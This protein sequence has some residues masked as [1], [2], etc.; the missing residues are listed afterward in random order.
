MDSLEFLSF[1]KN[2]APSHGA[3]GRR[4]A[5]SRA[6]YSAFHFTLALLAELGCTF[7]RNR[8]HGKVIEI[9]N[10][11]QHE[12]AKKA[13]GSLTTLQG[14]RVKADYNLQDAKAESDRFSSLS[15]DIAADIRSSLQTVFEACKDGA[16]KSALTDHL[17]N[18]LTV[19]NQKEFLARREP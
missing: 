6:Y 13:S 5:V 2:I 9:L 18:H 3:P 4:S 7:E 10:Q 15:I 19:T 14:N 12:G 8:N 17:R 1:A 11:V 16:R